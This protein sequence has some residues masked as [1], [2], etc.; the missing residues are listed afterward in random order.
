MNRVRGVL[1]VKE[2]EDTMLGPVADGEDEEE[3]EGDDEGRDINSAGTFRS[4]CGTFVSI[5]SAEAPHA[6]L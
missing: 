2:G 6:K 3:E 5:S 1:R 4:T